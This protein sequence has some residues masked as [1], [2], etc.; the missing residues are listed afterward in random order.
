VADYSDNPMAQIVM[1]EPLSK[2][3]GMTGFPLTDSYLLSP[4]QEAG[5]VS[6]FPMGNKIPDDPKSAYLCGKLKALC[7]ATGADMALVIYVQSRVWGNSSIRVSAG[8]RSVGDIKIAPIMFAVGKTGRPFYDTDLRN[9]DDLA[10][11]YSGL[12]YAGG[13]SDAHVDLKDPDGKVSAGVIKVIEKDMANVT[14]DLV[15]KIG[16]LK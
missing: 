16:K 7:E 10:P 1:K 12:I 11:A 13:Y 4:W 6:T 2:L 3:I 14:K 5:G 8:K 15:A 9:L